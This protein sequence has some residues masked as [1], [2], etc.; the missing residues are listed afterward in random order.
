MLYGLE[1]YITGVSETISFTETV[2]EMLQLFPM[3]RRIF[4]LNDHSLSR[5]SK[6]REFMEKSIESSDLPVDFV[7]SENKPF[8]EIL[9]DIRG[10]EI[11]QGLNDTLVLIGNYHSDSDGVFTR[12]LMCRS[13]L[14]QRQSILFFVLAIPI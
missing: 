5:S 8:S 2:Q 3:T 1:N 6:M 4:I 12:K 13:L 14:P 11:K 9:D 7:F 10:Y